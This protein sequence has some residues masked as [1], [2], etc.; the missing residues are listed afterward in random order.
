MRRVA[1]IAWLLLVGACDPIGWV[2]APPDTLDTRGTRNDTRTT[3]DAGAA[4]VVDD[5]PPPGELDIARARA[6]FPTTTELMRY[7]VGPGCAAERNECHN[8]EDYPDLST[9]GNLWNLVGLGCN[10]GL[11]ERT[12]VED[13]CE[14]RGDDIRLESGANDGFVAQIG[15]LATVPDDEGNFD[16][17]EIGIDREVPNDDGGATFVIVRDGT[18]L[19]ALGRGSSASMT[20]GERTIRIGR[21]G[22]ISDPSAVLQ[23]DENRNGV[24]GAE[25]GKMVRPGAARESYLVRRLLGRETARQRMPL[26][27]Q[28]DNP[29][30][31]NPPLS[32]DEMYALMSWINCMQ[33]GDGPYSP[34]RY[35]CEA[36]ADNEGSW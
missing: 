36:N 11:G 13:F 32:R 25:P 4:P 6:R 19:P 20:A 2:Q 12:E 23:G 16:Y 10:R 5:T 33:A 26:G 8:S 15:W 31:V 3:G 14:G 27:A 1:L 29:T 30:E 9:E 24:F 21:A 17:W 22:D 18:A 34:I 7:V 28:A 35:D